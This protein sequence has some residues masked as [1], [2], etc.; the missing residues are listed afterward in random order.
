MAPKIEKN[1]LKIAIKS[2]IYLNPF[3]PSKKNIVLIRH[4]CILVV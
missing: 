1:E 2:K 3:A 4:D